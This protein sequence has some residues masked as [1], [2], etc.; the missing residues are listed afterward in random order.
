MFEVSER[1]LMDIFEESSDQTDSKI[2][3]DVVQ[4]RQLELSVLDVVV[5]HEEKQPQDGFLVDQ[6]FV[7]HRS[8]KDGIGCYVLFLRKRI[9]F[10]NAINDLVNFLYDFDG[11]ITTVDQ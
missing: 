9:A 1:S 7:E 10:R 6:T 11:H 8:H 4:W 3:V 2:I 5:D